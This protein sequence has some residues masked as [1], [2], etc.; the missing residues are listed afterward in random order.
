[1]N[2]SAGGVLELFCW[3]PS[4]GQ[5]ELVFQH[6]EAGMSY[7]KDHLWFK[8]VTAFKENK[9]LGCVAFRGICETLIMCCSSFE[10]KRN[11]Y[12]YFPTA[13]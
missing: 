7:V 12:L 3:P 4:E 6:V 13:A 11:C 9:A 1:M 2:S 5:A 10:G 8:S